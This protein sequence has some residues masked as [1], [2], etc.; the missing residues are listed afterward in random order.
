M[1]C[2]VVYIFISALVSFVFKNAKMTDTIL[3]EK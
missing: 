1:W 2:I 3:T